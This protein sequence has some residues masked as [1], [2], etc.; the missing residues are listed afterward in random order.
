MILVRSLIFVLAFY[1]WSALFAIGM[2]PLLVCPRS[3]TVAAMRLW[4]AGVTALLP[5]LCDIRVEFRGLEHMPCG[6]AL[7]AAKH[8]CMFDTMAPFAVLSNACYVMKKELMIIPFY[9]WYSAKGGMIV[10]DREGHSK[11]LRQLVSDA[12]ER[13]KQGR[14]VVIFPEGHRQ[15]PGAPP[16]YKPGVAALYRDLDLPCTPMATNSGAHWPAHGFIRRP[17]TIVFEFLEPIPAGLKRGEFMRT[18]EG[19][20]ETASA[21]LLAE[22]P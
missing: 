16:D 10:I 15:D 18:L 21:A 8:Q 3:W 6:P 9:G 19:R 4:G 11:A 20:I 2:L 5:P 22:H 17:G 1:L 12:R 13:M 14:Q 7:I